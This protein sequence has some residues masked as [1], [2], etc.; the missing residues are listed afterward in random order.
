MTGKIRLNPRRFA[1]LAPAL[2]LACLLP[3]L[4]AVARGL[5]LARVFGDHMVLQQGG[6]VPVWGRAA[7]ERGVAV[8]FAGH[9]VKT[10]AGADG[11]WHATLPALPASAE[12]RT[13]RVRADGETVE[14]NDVLVGEVW[15][16]A[17]QSNMEWPLSRD[18]RARG[19]LPRATHPMV[20]LLNLDFAGKF[21]FAKPF[22]DAVIAR[23][24]PE[25]FYRG[26]WARCEPAAA[27]P[28][29][30]IGYYFARDLQAALGVPVGVVNLAVGGSPAEAWVSR[31]ALAAD[32]EL[33][34]MLEG[35]W[36]DN[37]ALEP[38]CRQRGMENLGAALKAGKPVPDADGGGPAHPFKPGFLWDA[39]PAPLLPFAMRGVLWYQGESNALS[40]R[41]TAQHE[42]LFPLLVRD[43]RARRGRGGFPFL[44]CQLSSIEAAGYPSENWP[45]FRDSQRRLR[46]KIPDAGMVVTSDAGARRDVHPRE[47]RVVG[48]RLARLALAQTYGRA[49]LPGGPEP[50]SASAAPGALR[51][52]FAQTGAGLRTSDGAAPRGFELAGADGQF[53]PAAARL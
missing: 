11:R 43:W 29:S 30:A 19:E 47:K 44:Y 49:I 17:G 35:S 23:L 4:D 50:V 7:P 21:I 24:T 42:R 1:R 15:L 41:R 53:H 25:A 3:A 26:A 6:P 34:P 18:A 32:A 45:E 12:P 5:A 20:R 51:V 36:L 16:C 46:E 22:P 39:G 9:V 48:A 27:A 13:L 8:A 40:A 33:R 52:A 2:A 10:T 31:E 38:W 37:P 28:F 14:I